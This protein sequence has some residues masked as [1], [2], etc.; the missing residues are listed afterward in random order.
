MWICCQQQL[1]QVL[2]AMQ[3]FWALAG[4][5]VEWVALDLAQ[6]LQRSSSGGKEV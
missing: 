4:L 3:L 6:A 5:S 1:Q 2:Q